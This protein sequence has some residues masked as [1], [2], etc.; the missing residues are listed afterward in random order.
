MSLIH[1]YGVQY[2]Y[3]G[4][5]ERATCGGFGGTPGDPLPA[6]AISKFDSMVG[7]TLQVVYRNPDV[8]I[9]KVIG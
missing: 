5:L 8:T 1:K 9:Y 2:V 6:A 4:Q 3:L 7:T